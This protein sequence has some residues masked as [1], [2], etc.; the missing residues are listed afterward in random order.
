MKKKST[1]AAAAVAALALGLS[2]CGGGGSGGGQASQS[3][4]QGAGAGATDAFDAA[5]GGKIFNPSTKKGG[6][7]KFANSGDWDSLAPANTYYGYAWNFGRLY[8]RT[9]TVFKT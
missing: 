6:T 8:W 7:L 2:A 5:N 1:L 3:A 4:G 9:L